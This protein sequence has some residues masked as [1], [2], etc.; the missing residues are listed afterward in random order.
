MAR[1][2]VQFQKGMSEAQFDDVY[3]TEPLCHAMPRWCGGARAY[4][5]LKESKAGSS[6]LFCRAFFR[7]TASHFSGRTL[8][9]RFRMPSYPPSDRGRLP[10][11]SAR[12][13]V[14]DNFDSGPER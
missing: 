12:R 2:K 13:A 14:E 4:P 11:W 10:G 8:A 5:L 6:F 3:G 1:N 7:K 9:R